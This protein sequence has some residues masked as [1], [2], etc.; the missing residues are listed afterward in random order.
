MHRV[1]F[2]AWHSDGEKEKLLKDPTCSQ[3]A[4]LGEQILARDPALTRPSLPWVIPRIGE[5]LYE[6]GLG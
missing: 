5:V 4:I 3:S 1:L 2:I 6:R